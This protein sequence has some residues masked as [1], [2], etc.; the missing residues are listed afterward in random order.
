MQ[1]LGIESDGRNGEPGFEPTLPSP[2]SHCGEAA[3]VLQ[4]SPPE[5]V[6]ARPRTVR[7][8]AELGS[9]CQHL[10]QNC[11][12]HRAPIVPLGCKGARLTFKRRSL[13]AG[14]ATA[15]CC[16]SFRGTGLTCYLLAGG[17][18]KHAQR[19]AAHESPRTTKLYDRTRDEISLDEI[20]RIVI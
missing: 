18:L 19:I 3:F 9:H 4:N 6:T 15:V 13:H 5:R 14:L 8:R 12:S 10:Q 11:R 2:I 16:H 1:A 7:N 20:E 17:S